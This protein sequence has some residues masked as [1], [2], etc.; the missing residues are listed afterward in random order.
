MKQLAYTTTSSGNDLLRIVELQKENLPVNL[1]HDII[2]KEGFVTVVHDLPVLK[3]MNDL[4]QHIIC[5]DEEKVVAYLLAMT[6]AAQHDIPVLIPMFELFKTIDYL[7]K[8]VSHHHYIVVGQVCVDKNYRG[9]G[10]LDKCYEK[11]RE[12]FKNKYDFAITEIATRNTRSI[13]AHQRIG[14]KEIYRYVSPDNEEWSIV[15]WEW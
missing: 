10:I 5:K 3:K 2:L 8:P 11:Y 12:Q 7:G 9:Q 4:E 15:V 1:T 13:K 14:F 6:A